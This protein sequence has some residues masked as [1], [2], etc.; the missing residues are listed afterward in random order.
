M[1]LVVDARGH[2]ADRR[3]REGFSAVA[4]EHANTF[5]SE[6]FTALFAML[7]KELGDEYFAKAQ[8]HLR[9]LK[10]RGGVLVS[11]E[12]GK[13]SKGA[14]YTLRKPPDRKQS[15]MSRILA[16]TPPVYSFH[17]HPR[18]ESGARIH[19]LK[20]DKSSPLSGRLN[21]KSDQAAWTAG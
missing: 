15:W 9:Q 4:A 16:Q 3:G 14:S 11:V 1:C 8:N 19:F 2:E 7:K 10:F 18:D 6:G 13:G 17:F 5:V 21:S 20:S 12:L